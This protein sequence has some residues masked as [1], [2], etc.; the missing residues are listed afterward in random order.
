MSIMNYKDL[1]CSERLRSSD[2]NKKNYDDR[3]E[4]EKDYHRI[5]GSASF[6][7]LQDKTQVFP[8]DKSDFIRTRL[9]HSLEVSSIAKSLGQSVGNLLVKDGIIDTEQGQAMADILLCSG[10]LHDI[11]NPPFGHF[12]ETVIREWFKSNLDVFQFKGKPVSSY[13]TE[14]QKNDL[15]NF[16]GNAQSLRVVTRLHHLIGDAGMNLTKPLI[17]TIIKYPVSSSEIDKRAGDIRLK[18]MGY[19]QADKDIFEVVTSSTGAKDKRH[20]LVFLL[21]AADDIAYSTA[22]LEDGYKKGIISFSKFRELLSE[23]ENGDGSCENSVQILDDY[24][25]K[26][27]KYGELDPELFALQNWTVIMQGKLINAATQSFYNQQELLLNGELKKDIFAGTKVENLIRSMKSIAYENIFQINDIVKLEIAADSIIS[28]LLDKFVDAA[29]NYDTD[30]KMTEKQ[31]KLIQLISPNYRRIY[32]VE[33]R[34]KAEGERL[35]LRLLLVTDSI[36]GMTDHY[37]KSLYQ[38]LNGIY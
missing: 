38:E 20:P 23:C 37:A 26:G 9:T 33:S 16:E 19:F 14:A 6:R 13:L 1:L 7:R 24:L 12:G 15:F 28:S 2:K 3:S 5:I 8:L 29:I 21:E 18:K 34:D 30:E 17:N 27:Q 31:E 36:A 22:D 11:G 35:Y 4:F 25:E 32:D 10:L